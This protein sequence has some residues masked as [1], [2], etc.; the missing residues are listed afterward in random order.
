MQIINPEWN[1]EGGVERFFQRAKRPDSK[2]K[3]ST[4]LSISALQACLA[5]H[6]LQL[7]LCL[8]MCS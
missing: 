8:Q 3:S 4:E 7:L 2:H 6:V 1:Y 5:E